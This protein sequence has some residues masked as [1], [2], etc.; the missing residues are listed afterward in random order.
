MSKQNKE[1]L[2]IILITSVIMLIAVYSTVSNNE[3]K[4]IIIT[5][6]SLFAA[7]A[8]FIQIRQGTKIAKAEFVMGLQ[9]T[10]SNSTGFS[11][12]FMTCWEEYK[13]CEISDDNTQNHQPDNN[14]N[15]VKSFLEEEDGREVLLN[16]LTFFESIYLMKEQGNLDFKILDE[17]FGRRFFIVVTNTTV[18]KEDLCKNIAYYDNVKKL[19]DDWVDYRKKSICKNIFKYYKEKFNNFIEHCKNHKNGNKN[20]NDSND[21]RETKFLEFK[22]HFSNKNLPDDNRQKN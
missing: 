5:L 18:Q 14:S 21:I 16:Y 2:V 8:V 6:I 1:S 7:V 20:G 15:S 13:N 22:K 12:L 9:E 10:Y 17:L 19:Y 3:L 4:D 11:K